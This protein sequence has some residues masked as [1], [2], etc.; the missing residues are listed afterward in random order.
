V[1]E[2]AQAESA[3]IERF[4]VRTKLSMLLDPLR[5]KPFKGNLTSWSHGFRWDGNANTE[6]QHNPHQTGTN[7]VARTRQLHAA[8]RRGSYVA[9]HD[10][11]GTQEVFDDVHRAPRICFRAPPL[12]QRVE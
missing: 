1:V 10:L 2:H 4:Y 8:R 6:P 11:L 5:A 9:E 7:T 3:L 12:L